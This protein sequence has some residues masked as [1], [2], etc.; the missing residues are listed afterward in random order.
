MRLRA[1]SATI[2]SLLLVAA[3]C[4]REPPRTVAPVVPSAPLAPGSAATASG[5]TSE[6]EPSS[7]AASSSSAAACVSDLPPADLVKDNLG[8]TSMTGLAEIVRSSATGPGGKG[9]APKTGYVNL[10]YEVRVLSWFA[11]GGAE[12][13]VLDQTAEAGFT[14]KAAGTLLFFSACAS[15]TDPGAAYEPDVGYFFPVDPACRDQAE[16]LGAKAKASAKTKRGAPSAC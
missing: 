4:T 16:A 5:P 7:A 8:S 3:A 14:P 6:P 1:G 15:K 13:L 2:V 10:R 9:P 12:R 11:G